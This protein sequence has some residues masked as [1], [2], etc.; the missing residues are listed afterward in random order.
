MSP[1]IFVQIFQNFEFAH[2]LA[3]SDNDK[4]FLIFF[5]KVTLTSLDITLKGFLLAAKTN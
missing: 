3:Q 1:E 4:I 5:Q 2:Y